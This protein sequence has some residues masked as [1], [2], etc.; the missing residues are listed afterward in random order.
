KLEIQV[1]KMDEAKAIWSHTYWAQF[2]DNQVENLVRIY[3]PENKKNTFPGSLTSINIATPCV[4]IRSDFLKDR[5][6]LRFHEQMRFGQDNYLWLLLSSEHQ[7]CLIPEILC[8]VRLRGT[9]T[10]KRARAHIQVR[11]M[12][13][14]YLKNDPSKVF[15]RKNVPPGIRCIYRLCLIEHRFLSWLENRSWINSNFVELTSKVIYVIPYT[16]FKLYKKIL[17]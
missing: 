4:M 9:N 14:K 7:I 12:I 17:Y 6:D 5:L 16:G 8:Y 3:G 10:V 15:Y 11:A 13:W 1:G 2:A